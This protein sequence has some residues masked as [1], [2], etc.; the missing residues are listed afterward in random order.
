MPWNEFS[1]RMARDGYVIIPGF[2]DV[3]RDI[4]PIREGITEI[5]RLVS[6]KHGA[7]VPCATPDQALAEG[8]QALIARNRAWG[9]EVYDAIKQ[10][11]AFMRL[12]AHPSN[13]DVVKSLRPDFIPGLAAGGYGIR[14]DSPAEEKF[15][16]YWHQEFPAQLRSLDGIVFWSPLVEIKPDMGPIELC[17]ASHKDGLVAV[18]NDEG[19][20]GRSGAYAL[21]L[22]D[23]Q[24]RVSRYER[25]APLTKPGDLILMDFLTLHQSGYNRSD[26]SRWSMQ[27]R[28]FNFADPVGI[29]IS[30]QGSFASGND[31]SDIMARLVGTPRS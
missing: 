2:Y 16:T 25:V 12:V 10:L 13:Q 30:W 14:I 19:G 9:A 27:F 26:R 4:A 23:E 3:E 29:E 8:Y 5:I 22:E 28:Y 15:R 20:V 21:R 24:E 6:G 17:V 31:F 18:R 1:E 11:P 7:D